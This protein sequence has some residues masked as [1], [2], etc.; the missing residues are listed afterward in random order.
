MM[1]FMMFNFK[2]HNEQNVKNTKLEKLMTPQDYAV[3][4]EPNLQ[5]QPILSK[6]QQDAVLADFTA[7]FNDY[8]KKYARRI[9]RNTEAICIPDSYISEDYAY[10]DKDTHEYHL[11]DFIATYLNNHGWEFELRYRKDANMNTTFILNLKFN[12]EKYAKQTKDDK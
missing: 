6:Q 10:Y 9:T 1:G 3:Y 5:Y 12:Y 8:L 11:L 2:K 4:V 7:W